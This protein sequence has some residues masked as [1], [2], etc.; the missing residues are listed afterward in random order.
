M[1]AQKP[2]ESHLAQTQP[3]ES[4]YRALADFRSVLRQFLA[5]SDAA[6]HAAGLT[7]Q[8]YQAL[9][10]I[11]VQTAAGTM[12]VGELADQLLV[13]P[14]SAAELVNR[15]EA[16]GLVKRAA[17]SSDRR[18]VLL[19][20]TDDGERRLAEL[21]RTQLQELESHREALLGLIDSLR[22]GSQDGQPQ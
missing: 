7:S 5:V 8:R 18:R 15:L 20:L 14:H 6:A 13:K 10:A 16:A 22:K 2:L 17:D 21:A 1:N 19:A 9:L 11:R 12:S 3:D 4:D